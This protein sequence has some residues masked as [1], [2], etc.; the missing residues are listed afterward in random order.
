[1]IAR[2]FLKQADIYI[3]DE[4]TTSLD[5][6]SEFL[7]QQAI[8]KIKSKATIIIVAHRLATV[9]NADQILFFGT[10]QNYRTRNT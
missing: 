10:W 3:F 2:A 7:I 1:M 9:K 8:D 4:A 6:Q 5:S